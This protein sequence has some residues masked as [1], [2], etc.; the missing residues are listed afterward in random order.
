MVSMWW[1]LSSTSSSS[2]WFS[3]SSRMS[4]VKARMSSVDDWLRFEDW[5]FHLPLSFPNSSGLIFS[6]CYDLEWKSLTC[7]CDSHPHKCP[8]SK[9]ILFAFFILKNKRSKFHQMTGK[10]SV[11][12]G[13][14]FNEWFRAVK[15]DQG[16]KCQNI[17]PC[18]KTDQEVDENLTK[19]I[20]LNHF[21]I[22]LHWQ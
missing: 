4:P 16:I 12:A 2:T 14:N 3:E 20:P 18:R 15:S 1:Q 21:P 5:S 6:E 13:Q 10:F 22:L 11:K 7:L 17:I 9:T 19:V 8:N